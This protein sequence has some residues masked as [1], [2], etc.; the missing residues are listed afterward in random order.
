MGCHRV[1][2]QPESILDMILDMVLDMVL[3]FYRVSRTPAWMQECEKLV[4]TLPGAAAR[5]KPRVLE[6]GKSAQPLWRSC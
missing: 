4:A 6:L 2:C 1:G 3:V 5:Q